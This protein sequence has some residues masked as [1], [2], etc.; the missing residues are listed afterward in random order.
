MAVKS[1][2]YDGQRLVE[3]LVDMARSALA[4]EA[5][6]G[7]PNEDSQDRTPDS[8]TCTPSRLHCVPD[9]GPPLKL[10]EGGKEDELSES[11]R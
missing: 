3:I 4:W 1:D 8:L 10:I 7:V 5:E 6:H 2:S 11:G 9:E